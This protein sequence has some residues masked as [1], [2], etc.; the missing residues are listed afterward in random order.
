ME[1]GAAPSDRAPPAGWRPSIPRPRRAAGRVRPAYAPRMDEVLRLVLDTSVL[2]NPDA[3]RQWGP[4]AE[5][6]LRGFVPAARAA[7]PRCEVYMPPSVLAELRT[8]LGSA[9][10]LEE[11]ELVVQMRAPNRYEIPVPGFLLY[12]LIEDIRGRID[13]GLRVA[14]TAVREAHP[15]NVEQSITRLRERYRDALRS[16]LLDSREDVD[17][18][19][20]AKELSAALV[21]CDRA[22]VR[23][24]ERLGI[25]LID[26]VHLRGILER[27]APG[28]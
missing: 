13:R 19:L 21:S 23:W 1:R 14:E 7:Q 4:S 3:S 9:E 25:R 15:E 22:V 27:L 5:A 8:F 11:L 10:P 26:P 12:E 18:I 6:A 28:A 20:L 17:L 16:G 2:T 24:A